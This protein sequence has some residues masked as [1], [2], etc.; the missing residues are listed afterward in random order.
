M[1]DV[2]ATAS[3]GGGG[4]IGVYTSSNS[5]PIIRQSKLSGSNYAL[6]QSDTGAAKVALSQLVGQVLAGPG[7]LQ[8]FNNYNENLAAVTCP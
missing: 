5:N 6:Q 7:S 1:I 4:D 3:G 2:T 8:C